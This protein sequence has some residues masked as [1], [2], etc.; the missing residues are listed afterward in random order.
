[1]Q[2]QHQVPDKVPEGSGADV[3]GVLVQILREIPEGSCEDTCWGS[4]GFC[5]VPEGSGADTLWFPVQVLGEVPEGYGA[6]TWLGSR[7]FWR[8][9]LMKF[10]RVY[11]W[12]CV[13]RLRRV[14]GQIPW[15]VSGV[16]TWWGSGGSRWRCV[17][18]FRRVPVRFRKVPVQRPC[19]VPEDFGGEDAWWGSG[20]FRCRYLV[21]FRKVPVQRPCEVP[22]GSGA[23]A[24]FRCFL[25]HKHLIFMA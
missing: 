21:R 16:A 24:L 12:R 2:L 22:E 15:E 8:R 13:V 10:W 18:R 6:D 19:E 7:G 17:V 23:D 1:M 14:A 3:P 25:W 11:R 4:G 20:G 9:Y 5:A